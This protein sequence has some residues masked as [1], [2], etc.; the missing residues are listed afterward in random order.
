MDTNFVKL[1]LLN[2]FETIFNLNYIVQITQI[3]ENKNI[4]GETWQ[5]VVFYN[6]EE[7]TYYCKTVEK[8]YL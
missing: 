1:T 3:D 7:T 2:D 4:N 5:V 8:V 6:N